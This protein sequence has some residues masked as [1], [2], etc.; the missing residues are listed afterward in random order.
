MWKSE[1]EM[2]SSI[3]SHETV[4]RLGAAEILQDRD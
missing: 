1:R 4:E 3:D 2:K